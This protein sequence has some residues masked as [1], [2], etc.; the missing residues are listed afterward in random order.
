MV[1]S[2]WDGIANFVA[3]VLVDRSSD[4]FR[5]GRLLVAGAVPLG[6]TFVLTYI[7]PVASGGWAIASI[8][9]AHLLFRTAYAGV[10]RALSG[11]DGADQRRRAATAPSS[12]ACACCSARRRP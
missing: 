6:L 11:D 1:A 2:I 9:V 8:F 7:P 12:P 10:E 3:G 5:Y 4:R